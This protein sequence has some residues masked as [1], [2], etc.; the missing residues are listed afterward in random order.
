MRAKGSIN[1]RFLGVFLWLVNVFVL[2]GQ[3]YSLEDCQRLARNNYPA[4]KRQKLIEQSKT[5]TLANVNKMWLPQVSVAAQASYQ[6]DRTSLP[7]DP[8]QVM[9]LTGGE[10]IDPVS[11]DQYKFTAQVNQLIYDGGQIRARRQMESARAEV[12]QR[13]LETTLYAI[14]ERVNEL[15]FG[16]LLQADLLKQNQ[17][18]QALLQANYKRMKA[19]LANGTAS[20]SDV[21]L[22]EVECLKAEQHEISIKASKEAFL[23]MLGHLTGEEMSGTKTV[24][25]EPEVLKWANSSMVTRPELP[26][27]E[28]QRALLDKQYKQLNTGLVP[29]VGFFLT[30]GYGR[31]GLNALN[32]SF[33]AFYVAGVHLSWDLSKFYTIKNNRRLIKTQHQ[34]VQNQRETFLFN[35]ET[36]LEKQ[37]REIEE[38]R[39]LLKHDERII[40]LRTSIR[41]AGEAKLENGVY[42][43]TDLVND[44]NEEDQ[45]RQTASTQKTQY[46][47]AIYEKMYI[48]GIK[49]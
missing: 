18:R 44:I 29:Q 6:S 43:T 48:Q 37:N 40:S 14:R 32:N 41:K 17:L 47:M 33:D 31:P 27:F 35:I 8:E 22:L 19:H 25:T 13:E 21:Q 30:G 1:L 12:S 4:I 9:K 34:F 39:A 36:Q 5:Y 24:L 45:A 3:T 28:A 23:T 16:S 26:L 11:K 20:K 7:F 38:I 42:T 10:A 2:S 46:L 15:Y 49:K